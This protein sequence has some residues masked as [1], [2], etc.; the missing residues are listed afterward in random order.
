[1][2]IK[3]I[4]P[5]YNC[6]NNIGNLIESV[7]AQD[8][9]DWEIHISCDNCEESKQAALMSKSLYNEDIQ[10]KIFVCAF[11]ERTYA[12][13]NICITMFFLQFCNEDHFIC[14][15]IDGDDELC[16]TNALSLIADSYARGNHV[17]W[18]QYKRDD[19]GGCVS[20]NLPHDADPYRYPWVSSHFRTFGS[21]IYNKISHGNFVDKDGAYFKRAYDQALMLPMLHYCNKHDLPTEFIPEVCYKYNH[22]G[23]STPK[24]EHSNGSYEYNLAKFIRSRGYIE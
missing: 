6:A 15:I 24:S 1:M 16:N 2:K 17:V 21:W 9:K 19:D 22:N 7:V 14:G 10:E 13:L 5:A 8:Y 20:A 3:L 12:L 23:S 4:V 11:P 18:T